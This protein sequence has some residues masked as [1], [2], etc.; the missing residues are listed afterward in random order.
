MSTT[1]SSN[2]IIPQN[3]GNGFSSTSDDVVK[4]SAVGVIGTGLF[5]IVD[6]MTQNPAVMAVILGGAAAIPAVG[7]TIIILGAMIAVGVYAAK[8]IKEQFAKYYKMLRTIDEFI[9]LLHKI[10]KITNLTIFISTT[11]DFDINVDEVIQQMKIIFN[12]F[13]E[14]LKLEEGSYT[15]IEGMVMNPLT[16]KPEIDI[17]EAILEAERNAEMAETEKEKENEKNITG[18]APLWLERFKFSVTEWNKSLN[19]DIIKLNIHLT[20]TMSEF[21]IILNVIQMNM[22]VNAIGNSNEQTNEQTKVNALRNLTDKNNLIKDSSEYHQTRVGILIHDILKL[23]VD[24]V[25]CKARAG[26]NP[27]TSLKNDPMCDDNIVPYGPYRFTNYRSSLHTYIMQ[28]ITRLKDSDYDEK[29]KKSIV[30]NVLIP[31]SGLLEKAKISDIT[32]GTAIP[33]NKKEVLD[34]FQVTSLSTVEI[35]NINAKLDSIITTI[36]KDTNGLQKGGENRFFSLFNKSKN[37]DPASE[38][39]KK[40]KAVQLI[41]DEPYN[42]ITD[43][44]LNIFLRKVYDFSKKIAATTE[45]E[46]KKALEVANAMVKNNAQLPST[47]S[48]GGSSKF[49]YT[50]KKA[51]IVK[52]NPKTYK[53]RV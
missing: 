3:N 6:K 4:I 45:E 16:A 15:K 46:K 49:L 44:D 42:L 51:R 32:P 8:R 12:R 24:F 31:Y 27:M 1:Q 37:K 11:Y 2:T 43:N 22:I 50:R 17:N 41:I 35:D 26:K 38:Q 29:I 48:K 25:Y 20:T 21:T 5:T 23:R 52:H 40:D 14:V 39:Q 19:T 9:I 28:I 7:Q 36:P 53:V 30:D 10:Q 13:D 47:T 18:G 33:P 34:A